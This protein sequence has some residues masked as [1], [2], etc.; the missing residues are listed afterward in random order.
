M[1]SKKWAEAK[2]A[3]KARRVGL[4]PQPRNPRGMIVRDDNHPNAPFLRFDTQRAMDEAMIASRMAELE[5]VEAE[6]QAAIKKANKPKP[7][8][9]AG[10]VTTR[11]IN[12]EKETAR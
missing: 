10:K 4:K 1:A 9:K 11:N 5:R 12:D 2:E 3:R 6:R 7:R 8:P